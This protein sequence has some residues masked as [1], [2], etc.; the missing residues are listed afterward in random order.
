MTLYAFGWNSDN[1]SREF[2]QFVLRKLTEI[3]ITKKKQIF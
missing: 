1:I 2:L 3:Y